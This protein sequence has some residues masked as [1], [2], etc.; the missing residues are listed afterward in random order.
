MRR[1]A[2]S[3]LLQITQAEQLTTQY[4]NLKLDMF[5]FILIM[6][7][8]DRRCERTEAKKNANWI[9]LRR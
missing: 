6:E 5:P 3:L 1:P 7:S 2:P 8:V 4:Q 9:H